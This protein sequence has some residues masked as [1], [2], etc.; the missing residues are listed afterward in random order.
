MDSGQLFSIRRCPGLSRCD[1]T[2]FWAFQLAEAFLTGWHV[3]PLDGG[4]AIWLEP[5]DFMA[6]QG[7]LL[8]STLLAAMSLLFYASVPAYLHAFIAVR[9]LASGP[10]LPMLTSPYGV[11]HSSWLAKSPSDPAISGTS[12]MT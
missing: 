11:H 7:T 10:P 2:R 12:G 1:H 4:C 5:M 8:W 6:T 9:T 3:W